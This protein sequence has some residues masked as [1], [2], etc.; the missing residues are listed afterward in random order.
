[1]LSTRSMGCYSGFLPYLCVA[2]FFTYLTANN[3]AD[4]EAEQRRRIKKE[5][6]PLTAN[7]E[8]CLCIL[9]GRPQ[10]THIRQTAFCRRNS[11]LAPFISDN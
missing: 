8:E 7:Q 3:G 6:L 10:W 1:M 11:R 4:K 2:H 9:P 5:M